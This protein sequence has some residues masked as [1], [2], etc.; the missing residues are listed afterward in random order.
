MKSEKIILSLLALMIGLIVAGGAFFIY[1]STKTISPSNIKTITIQKTSPTPTPSVML[2]IVSPA[3]ESVVTSKVLTLTGTTSPQATVV[4]NTSGTDTVVTPA[5][6][7][8]FSLTLTLPDSENTITVTAIAPN[9]DEVKK[10][11]TVGYTTEDF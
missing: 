8:A 2:S 10:V 5:S 4:V 6:T 11:L 9:G 1:Q 7:G 3:D